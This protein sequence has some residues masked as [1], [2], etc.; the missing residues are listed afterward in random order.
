MNSNT[1]LLNKNEHER[2]AWYKDPRVWVLLVAL[3]MFFFSVIEKDTHPQSKQ[4]ARRNS[5]SSSEPIGLSNK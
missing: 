4:T 2:F 1:Q 3:L 5:T